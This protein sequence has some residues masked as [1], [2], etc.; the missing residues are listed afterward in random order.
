[1]RTIRT[2]T[3]TY[4]CLPILTLLLTACAQVV[5]PGG[6][7]KDTFAPKPLK[8]NPDS[9]QLNFNSK[10]ILIDFNEF[11][12]L[13]D[14]NT[15]LI[16]SPPLKK[17]PE[18]SVKNKTLSISL[19]KSEELKPNTTY[20]INFG[21]AIQDLNENNPL[22]DFRYIFST[23]N[24]IDSL[25]LKGR[26]ENAFDL[27]S[28]EGVVVML[29]SD[30]SDSTVFTGQPDYFAK[31]LSDGSFNLRN[32]RAGRYRLVA[33]KD[34]NSNY[35]YDGES[36]M[37]G[38]L[39][40]P[41][42]VT[43]KKEIMVDLF[44]EPAKKTFLKKYVH[45]TYGKVSLYL[46]QGS[47]SLHLN[48]LN[49]TDKGVQEYVEYSKDKDSVIYWFKNFQKDSLILELRNGTKVMDTLRIKLVTLDEAKKSKKNPFKLKAISSPDGNQS[50]DLGSTLGLRFNHPVRL[51]KWIHA[52]LKADTV[53]VKTAAG[54]PEFVSWFVPGDELKLCTIDTT[55]LAEDPEHP[56]EYVKAPTA[57]LFTDWKENTNYHFFIPPGTFED[58][59]G[60]TNDSIKVNFKT[61]EEKYYGTVKVS[62]PN[63]TDDFRHI[64]QLVNE[65]G[66]VIR[67]SIERAPGAVEYDY[68]PPGKYRLK[69]IYD[70]NNNG[71][72]DSGNY[73][74]KIQP[75][76]VVFDAET[77]NIRSNWD[78]ELE[79][80]VAD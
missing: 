38:F 25:S 11:I 31:T 54:E 61:R 69:I 49:N 67:E 58:F 45:D 77:I 18:I 37:I 75:E 20:S 29:Y 60:L 65:S 23:G 34:V 17:S 46:N 3:V 40:A 10:N 51:D 13:K 39:N 33:V 42:D 24:F 26:V 14:L 59:F 32:L 19:D 66:K 76:K 73:L 70:G 74:Q 72:W 28:M 44:R 8:Y 6:G 48:P 64:I 4:T 63:L 79:W 5:A 16:I 7:P 21:N 36:E 43:E 52:G 56:G 41:V 2:L 15:Q 55:M 30:M 9:A 35:K 22:K 71:K 78:A 27:S 53:P 57:M 12:Q 1:M 50:F 80:K 47:D 68:L 62:L